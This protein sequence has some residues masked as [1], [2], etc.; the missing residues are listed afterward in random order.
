MNPVADTQ[1]CVATRQTK[2]VTIS[3]YGFSTFFGDKA[4]DVP[5]GLQALIFT[6]VTGDMLTMES[7]D[8]IPANTGV[9]LYGTANA[10]YNLLETVTTET[11][12]DNLLK[13][14]LA[15]Q[16]ID[17]SY[18]HYILGVYDGD[19]G[20]FWPSGTTEGVG[21][22]TNKGG[23]AY[24]ELGDAVPAPARVR[25]FVLSGTSVATGVEN[26][27]A[28]PQGVFYDLL[29]RQVQIPQPGN[30]YIRDGKK[31]VAY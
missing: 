5:G 20:M 10:T 26:I 15:D 1:S 31:V 9:V 8:L 24:L 16:I 19:C 14:S 27:E 18:V 21:P 6:G 28:T 2:A 7:V 23:K 4:Y 30:I 3:A 12:S 17:N 29:G 13:G 11:Y 22:F 25:G